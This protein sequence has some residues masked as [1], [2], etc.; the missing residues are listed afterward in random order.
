MSLNVKNIKNRIDSEFRKYYQMK[1]SS[2]KFNLDWSKLASLKIMGEFKEAIKQL[3]DL[4]NYQL[5][6]PI[7]KNDNN[8]NK[9]FHSACIY[10]KEK[11]EDKF[12]ADLCSGVEE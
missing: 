10:F 8:F 1:S 9:G 5:K 2:E 3:N 11:I 4:L 7:D 6:L 12:G